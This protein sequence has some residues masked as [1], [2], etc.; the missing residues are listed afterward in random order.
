[1]RHRRR[2]ALSTGSR[3]VTPHLASPQIDA[4]R[5]TP[6]LPPDAENLPR[7]EDG[8]PRLS[9]WRGAGCRVT[10]GHH[11]PGGSG[12]GRPASAVAPGSVRTREGAAPAD[13][14][15]A[16]SPPPFLPTPS[17]WRCCPSQFTLSLS[18][19]SRPQRCSWAVARPW[20]ARG[21]PWKTGSTES[22]HNH[23]THRY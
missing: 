15:G 8:R 7:T 18:A 4:P 16:D 21:V 10:A 5:F 20:R 14:P 12:D 13:A 1:M 23:R 11:R 22:C 19:S 17:A 3:R 9:A 6:V 2:V